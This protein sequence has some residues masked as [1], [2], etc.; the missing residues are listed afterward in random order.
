[1]SACFAS[2][3]SVTAC[4]GKFVHDAHT[5]PVREKIFH[6]VNE[7]TESGDEFAHPSRCAEDLN[8][9]VDPLVNFC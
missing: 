9:L 5:K 3:T 7:F 4:A 1:M 6:F 2:V 8:L